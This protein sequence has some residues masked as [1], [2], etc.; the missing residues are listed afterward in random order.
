[1]PERIF[2]LS[3]D[4]LVRD[5]CRR[6]LDLYDVEFCSTWSKLYENIPKGIPKVILLDYSFFI[7]SDP[8]LLEEFCTPGIS[9]PLILLT[10]TDCSYFTRWFYKIGVKHILHLPCDK[11]RFQEIVLS[12]FTSSPAFSEMRRCDAPCCQ[13]LEQLLGNSSKMQELKAMIYH[14]SQ[15]DSPLLL[16]GESGT[17]KT[18]LARII[19]EMSPRKHNPFCG[20]NMASIPVSLAESELFG[21]TKGA[22]TDA[23][24][25]EGYF[26][27]AKLGTLFLDEIGDLPLS[28]QPKLLHVLEELVYTKVGSTKK[29]TCN[30]RFLFATNADLRL[31]VDQGLFRGDLYYRISIL[32]IEMP[33]LRERK[34]DI[35]QLAQHFLKPYKK[36]LSSTSI[37]KLMDYHWPG[38]VRELKNCLTRASILSS[39][40]MIHDG[41]ISF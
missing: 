31:L 5:L 29:I 40:E 2:V 22:Y 21:T 7:S 36:A 14:F 30:T 16:T 28:V 13:K 10:C 11:T 6:H 41:H 27:A 4:P 9:I 12:S 26:S 18:Y 15:T 35:P 38:N 33:P 24:S 37:Q 34:T 3:H 20:V 23:I 1:M 39:K 25:R 17:G 32:P 8:F 19:H